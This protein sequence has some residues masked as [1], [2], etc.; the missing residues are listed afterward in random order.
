MSNL[1][2]QVLSVLNELFPQIKVKK[3]EPVSYK[4]QKLFLDF[5]IPQLGL[6]I[7]VHGN[8]HDEFV[9]MFHGTGEGFRAS[10]KRDSLKEE[11]AG[12][13]GHIFVVVRENEIPITKEA[14]LEK[15][16][17]AT[18]NGQSE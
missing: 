4:G 17:A 18:D 3:E 2:D 11:W 6:V 1:S 10:K 14:L 15:I 8:Q 7:E 12:V 13:N 16:D 9:P 5:W